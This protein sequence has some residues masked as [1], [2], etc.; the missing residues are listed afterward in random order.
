MKKQ[1]TQI[2]KKRNER[3]EITANVTEMQTLIREYYEQ[4]YANK[5]DNLDE[6]DK[7][8]KTYSLLRLNQEEI[9]N[10]C[11]PMI[12]IENALVIKKIPTNKNPGPDSFTGEI[13]Q[14]YKKELIY[15]LLNY[16]K[17]LQRKEHSQTHSMRPPSP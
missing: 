1:R 3:G 8:L 4:L 13:Y 10:L 2:N 17:K 15:I 9:D 14:T 7:F 5:L 6:K 11:I 12:N 16:S